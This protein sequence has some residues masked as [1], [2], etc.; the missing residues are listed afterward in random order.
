[1]VAHVAKPASVISKAEVFRCHI[2]KEVN[3]RRF[4]HGFNETSIG[5]PI[6]IISNS[7][8]YLR[9]V[10]LRICWRFTTQMIIKVAQ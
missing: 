5:P 4:V 1:M 7:M 8:P 9:K 10:L 2:N 3:T 6:F